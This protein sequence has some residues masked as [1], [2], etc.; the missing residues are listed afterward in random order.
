[1]QKCKLWVLLL[2]LVYP[3]KYILLLDEITRLI[4]LISNY[5][6]FCIFTFAL[7]FIQQITNTIQM[8]I[9]ACDFSVWFLCDFCMISLWFLC[10][11][12]VWFWLLRLQTN[13]SPGPI[14]SAKDPIDRLIEFIPTKAPYDPRWMLSGRPS[15]CKTPFHRPGLK[16]PGYLQVSWLKGLSRVWVLKS[17]FSAKRRL[18]LTGSLMVCITLDKSV[19]PMTT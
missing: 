1:M 9:S 13:A 4:Y 3:Y 10:M 11:I 5:S 8:V 16:E 12:S 2:L 7:F 18:T 17:P 15:Q 14:L 6:C 19:C